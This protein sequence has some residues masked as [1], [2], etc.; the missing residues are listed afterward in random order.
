MFPTASLPSFKAIPYPSEKAVAGILG[1]RCEEMVHAAF[2]LQKKLVSF[3]FKFLT[4]ALGL[5]LK[6]TLLFFFLSLK[7]HQHWLEIPSRDPR[8]PGCLCPGPG[9]T[10]GH[11]GME[12][13]AR[14]RKPRP[15]AKRYWRR[16][17]T[18]WG[19]L[20]ARART[21]GSRIAVFFYDA[22]LSL[23]QWLLLVPNSGKS[24]EFVLFKCIARWRD[25]F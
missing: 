12:A 14:A 4:V 24:P 10:Q 8:T 15:P 3:F 25:Q 11:P 21:P 23:I 20:D 17:R 7:T 18:G 16:G 6:T 19:S 22:G 1:S 9:H 5:Q 2:F 13:L